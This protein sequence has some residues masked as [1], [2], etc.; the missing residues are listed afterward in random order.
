MPYKVLDKKELGNSGVLFEM[1]LHTPLIARKAYAGNFVL[2]RVNETGERFPLTIADYNRDE[3]TIT[4]VFQVVGKSTKL[5]SHQNIGDE[6]LDVVGPL[7]NR[8]HIQKYEYPVILIGGGSK[9][10]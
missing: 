2:L 3:G 5:L 9:V 10:K 1:V 8:I 7:G 6:I 4:I